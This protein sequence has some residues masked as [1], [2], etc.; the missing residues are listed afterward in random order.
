[1]NFNELIFTMS[2][3]I[4]GHLSPPLNSYI[5]LMCSYGVELQH[6]LTV[7]MQNCHIWSS[8][9]P[10][11]CPPLHLTFLHNRFAD[12]LATSQVHS[13]LQ[14]L[15]FDPL[16]SP[17]LWVFVYENSLMQTRY[18]IGSPSLRLK[19]GLWYIAVWHADPQLEGK[20]L[21][22]SKIS[23]KWN[24]DKMWVTHTLSTSSVDPV[25]ILFVLW[26]CHTHW[27]GNPLLSTWKWTSECT[28]TQ[29]ILPWAN[30]ICKW[31]TVQFWSIQLILVY[32]TVWQQVTTNYQYHCMVD[33]QGMLW[34]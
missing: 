6:S 25:N 4:W 12:V 15:S 17:E 23:M 34:W 13:T 30:S 32:V 19:P 10:S 21:F 31:Q 28:R 29:K 2:S 14:Y 20:I 33:I 27:Q 22:C 1:M 9:P 11:K 16:T 7:A 24:E 5:I 18:N 8:D 26:T 3:L